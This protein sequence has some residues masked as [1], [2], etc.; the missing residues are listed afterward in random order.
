MS[1]LD[2][3]TRIDIDHVVAVAAAAAD[4]VDRQAR[5]PH[6]A[7]DAMKQAGLL[8]ASLPIALGGREASITE[9]AATSRALGAACASSGMIYAMHHS[10]ALG[11]RFHSTTPATAELTR[12]VARTEGLIAS[13]TTEITTGGDLQSSTCA[14]EYNGDTIHLEKNAPVISYGDYADYICVT[15]RRDV[16]SPPSDQ[17]LVVAP[18]SEVTLTRTSEWDTLGFRGTCS[19]GFMLSL[20]TAAGHVM[21][22]DYASLSNHTMQPSAHILWAACWLGIA[23][24][25]VAKAGK[26]VRAAAR[27]SPGTTP[28]QAAR[29]GDLLVDHQRFEAAVTDG[30]NRYEKFLASGES[31]ATIGFSVAMNNL[32]ITASTA[33]VDV[34]AAAL[35]ITGI[36][37]YRQDSEASMGRLLRDAYGPALMVSNDRIRANNSRLVLALRGNS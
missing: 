28:P 33:V 35:T 30:I 32:K 16:T 26:E 21:P 25:A 27:R 10:Q 31:E 6:E 14:V 29:F 12:E 9:L 20:D 17:V 22:V 34:V 5:F 24:A 15:A 7:V 4:D 19:P 13:A 37:G 3:D 18:M 11:L 36:K 8:S 1:I 23:D 2:A